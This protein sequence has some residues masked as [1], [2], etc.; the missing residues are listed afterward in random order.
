MN[1][2]EEHLKLLSIFHYILAGMAGL[3]ALFPILHLIMG[4][5]VICTANGYTGNG[6]SPSL[7]G[8]VFVIFALLFIG[9]GMTMAVLILI[10]GRFLARRKHYQFCFVMACL[11]CLFMPFGTILGVFTILVLAR[12]SVKPLF[13][14]PAQP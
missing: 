12:A 3:L 14:N 6:P 7:I 8:W 5:I 9:L 2:D 10:T 11:E 4:L 13:P 1:Q